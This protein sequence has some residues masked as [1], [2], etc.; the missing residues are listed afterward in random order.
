MRMMPRIYLVDDDAELRQGLQRMLAD[1]GCPT[2][3]FTSGADFL[4]ACPGL[5]PGCVLLDLTLA[6]MDGFEVQRE[7]AMVGY[8][9][10]V[11]VLTGHVSRRE[12]ARAMLGGPP[13]SLE[14]PVCAAELFASMFKAG[15]CLPGAVHERADPLLAHAFSLLSRRERQILDGM[16]AGELTKQTAARLAIQESTVKGYRVRLKKKLCVRSTSQLIQLAVLAELPVKS[17]L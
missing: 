3:T 13:V 8:R 1:A 11:V 2:T 14:K 7:L 10:P 17:R 6:G 15:A 9:W 12:M 4:Q 16:M 5:E